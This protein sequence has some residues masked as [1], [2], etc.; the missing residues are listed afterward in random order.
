[1]LSLEHEYAKAARLIDQADGLIIGAGAG[2]GIDSGL[3]DF[4]GP[5]GFWKVRALGPTGLLDCGHS[6]CI[7]ERPVSGSIEVWT[8]PIADGDQ[9]RELP[10]AGIA[11]NGKADVR[12][13]F[14]RFSPELRLCSGR[15]H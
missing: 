14:G 9:K 12:Y 7:S 2:M 1:M 8:V 5:G 13:V 6:L 10:F 11:Q 15:R 3:P 4:R